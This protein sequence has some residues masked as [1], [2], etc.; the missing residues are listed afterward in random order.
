M[1]PLG[2]GTDAAGS[3]RVPAALSGTVG[4]KPGAG[5]YSR[6]G[7]VLVSQTQDRVGTLAR[8]VRDL[9]LLDRVLS[10][11]GSHVHPLPP[12]HV[13][14]GVGTSSLLLTRASRG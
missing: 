1:V 14:L 11:V 4:F 3:V 8:S 5:R 6:D 10:N 9:V 13:R 2:L 12:R 7:V